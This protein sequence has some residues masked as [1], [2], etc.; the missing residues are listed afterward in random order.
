M[1]FKTLTTLGDRSFAVAAPR[2]WN[3]LPYAIRSSPSVASFKKVPEIED[4]DILEQ[5]P[6]AMPD[7]LFTANDT[8]SYAETFST[9][10]DNIFSVSTLICAANLF[11]SFNIFSISQESLGIP[12]LLLLLLFTC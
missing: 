1:K 4:D 10:A 8:D 9:A 7:E 5:D 11:T 12:S 2:L 6:M 3:L